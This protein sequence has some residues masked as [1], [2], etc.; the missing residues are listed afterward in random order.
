MAGKFST[1]LNSLGAHNMA[2]LI[3]DDGTPTT[4]PDLDGGFRGLILRGLKTEPVGYCAPIP[5]AN[6]PLTPRGEWPDLIKQGEAD[7][8]FLSHIRDRGNFGGVMPSLDQNGQGFC[9]AYGTANAI[10]LLRAKAHQPYARLSAHAIGCKVKNFRDEGGWGALSLEFTLANGCP[11][12]AHW[13]E[14]SMSRTNDTPETWANAKLYMPDEGFVD[15]ASPVYNR[16]LTFDQVMTCLLERIPVV[17][18]FDWW[19]HC[20]CACDPV[21]VSPGQFGVRIWNSWGD[22][23]SQNGMGVLTGSKAIPNNAVAPTT[24]LAS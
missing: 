2:E 8:S 14:K 10:S 16:D 22:S 13:K 15:L 5:P 9:W 23:W 19:G 17:C 18:D 12:V 24:V 6:I 7:K 11:D 20:V 1:R 3:F 4:S 21:E